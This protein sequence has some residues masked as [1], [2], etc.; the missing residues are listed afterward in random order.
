MNG[1]LQRFLK[2]NVDP[3]LW[4]DWRWQLKNVFGM[5]ELKAYIPIDFPPDCSQ[6]DG[7]FA[8]KITPYYI[9]LLAKEAFKG[10]LSRMVLPDPYELI[11]EGFSRDPF[12]EEGC[13]SCCHAVKQR[14]P[15]RVLIMCSR[16]CA[17]NCRH[18]TR[19]GLLNSAEI[20]GCEID[21]KRA[22]AFVRSRPQ[23]RE[24][25]L[26]GGDPLLLSDQ[27]IFDLVAAFAEMP[28]IDAVRIG[29]RVLTTLPSR[30]TSKLAMGLGETRKLWINT[31]FNHVSEITSEAERACRL[32]ADVGIPLSN[33]S[34]LL[35]GIND[36]TDAMFDLCTSLQRN[37]V[38][39]YYVFSCDPV[40]G[41]SHFRVFKERAIQIENELA[42]RVGG[43]AL[44]RFVE[45][46]P[47]EKR[48]M[49][50]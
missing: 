25:L 48:K 7:A 4:T 26:S 3:E 49:P 14:F 43:L 50:L 40:A 29:S 28:Q 34:V 23:V 32:L 39:P 38:R 15:D 12:G 9:D 45:D 13:A 30:I 6:V 44:P 16:L 33:Q 41:I 47:G 36:S 24:V 2:D 10:P 20:I 42:V 5:E 18:C 19:K 22:L 46:L 37:R 35:R 27:R 1:Y 11:G 31:Q 8:V 17:V 21:I